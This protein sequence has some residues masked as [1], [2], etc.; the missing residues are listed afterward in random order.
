MRVL[1]VYCHPCP[2][3]YTA[4]IRDAVHSSVVALG[5]ECDIVDLYAEGF[6]AAMG[7]EERRGYHEEGPNL[8]PVRDH[9][10]R[11]ARADALVFVYPTWWFNLPAM[12]KGWL[13]RVLVPGFAFVMPTHSNRPKPGLTHIRH[14]GAFTTCGADFVTSCLMGFPARRTLLRGVR[15][16]CHPLART[17]YSAIYKIDTSS[18]VER[19]RHLEAIPQQVEK[20]LAPRRAFFGRAPD[21]EQGLARRILLDEQ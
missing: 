21:S 15:S 7:R 1:L 16:N 12:L 5:H 4:A 20:L 19:I 10:E 18:H 8:A 17:A 6:D 14:V 11:L 2:E 3:S 9:A 13:D